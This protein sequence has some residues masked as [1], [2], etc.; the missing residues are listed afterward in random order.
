MLIAVA[1]GTGLL[2]SRVVAALAAEGHG[3]RALSRNPPPTPLPP[4]AEH[5]Q[6]DLVTATG[7]D[8]ALH[9]VDAV[10]DASDGPPNRKAERI[11][12]GG[13]R[14]LLAAGKSAG[15]RHH[16]CVSI[17]GC[18]QIPTTYYELK[19]RQEREVEAG[20]LPWTILRATQFH[21]LV[22]DVFRTAA[23]TRVI[24]APRFPLQP[25]DVHA[26]ARRTVET[27]TGEPRHARL[28]TAGPEIRTA[29]ELAR[30]YKEQTGRHAAL[31]P[32]PLPRK[33]GKALRAGHLTN[34]DAANQDSPTFER[35]LAE[36]STRAEAR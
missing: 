36:A 3:V 16:V 31:L 22:A 26:A 10:V 35:W 1:G 21:D 9:G 14:H 2:G 8:A 11:F 34:A 25:I 28:D 5:A 18:D 32:L 15:V 20:P 13:T 17:V 4:N 29:P 27:A 33:L 6:V 12:V 19:A 24:P 30:V 23:K 7:L